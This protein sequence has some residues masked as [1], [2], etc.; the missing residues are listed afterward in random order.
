MYYQHNNIKEKFYFIN[1]IIFL[2]FYIKSINFSLSKISYFQSKKQIK[3]NKE[4]FNIKI[5]LWKKL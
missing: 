2:I 5:F 1:K 4:K 3:D